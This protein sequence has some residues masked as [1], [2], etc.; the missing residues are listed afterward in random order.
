MGIAV[1]GATPADVPTLEQLIA[2][3][4]REL[5]RADYTDEQ[6]EA[7]LRGAMGV[8]SVL[9]CDETYFVAEAE[10]EIVACGGWSRR[11]T[12]FGSDARPGRE[13]AVLDPA[14]EPAKIRAFFVHP[15]WARR[16]IG[17]QLLTHCEAEARAH[18]F[19]AV[20]LMATLP[21]RRLYQVQGY[22]AGTP[23]QHPL[24][25]GLTIEL[26]PMRKELA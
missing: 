8:D 25:D 26:V 20:E 7:A 9:I 18:G 14:R 15:A 5:S 22:V 1:R 24:G 11:R 4:A 10:R 21:G 19:R 17:R 23:V 13:A 16:G 2:A 6:I 12:L 3:S